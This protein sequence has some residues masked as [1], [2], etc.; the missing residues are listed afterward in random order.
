MSEEDNRPHWDGRP[1]HYEVWFLTLV[2]PLTGT[3][4]WIRSSLLAPDRG[5][6]SAGVWFARFD[7]SDPDRTFGIHHRV[8]AWSVGSD[9]FR[10][11]IG[12]AEMGS[13]YARGSL[14]EGG[15]KVAW[16]LSFPTEAPTYRPLP[17]AL[18][19]GGVASTKPL[20]PNVDTRASGT[21][22]V[23]GEPVEIASAPA[24]QG[25]VYGTRHAERWV[26]AHCA[27]F[28]DE[29]AVVHAMTAQARRGPVTTPFTTF[30]GVQWH[31]RWIR[32]GKIS[33]RRDFSLGVW[34]IRAQNRLYR[35]AGR[36]EVPP[37][38]MLR[39]TYHDPDGTPRYC[40][41]SEISSCRLALFERRARGY[42][43]VALLESNGTTHAEWAGRTPASAVER[44]FLEA[45]G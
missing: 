17:R 35:L 14:D 27:D 40:H 31:G 15:R 28:L 20:S 16:D 11:R 34:R 38:A 33:G 4:Y 2:D 10:V 43:E 21:I 45:T 41:N 22:S 24:Q 26:W 6:P 7:R 30:I 37:Q 12:G 39:A 8:S 3:G 1:G 44:E 36:I 25:H 29:T 5:E 19:L 9:T 23:D 32:L 42:E 18:Y 13:G